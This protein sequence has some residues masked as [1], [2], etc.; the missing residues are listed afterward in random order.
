MEASISYFFLY[1][2]IFGCQNKFL[3]FCGCFVQFYFNR[4]V[5]RIQCTRVLIF[6][7]WYRWFWCF[8]SIIWSRM[9]ENPEDCGRLRPVK[10]FGIR[11]LLCCCFHK[12]SFFARFLKNVN[13]WQ[14]PTSHWIQWCG[15]WDFSPAILAIFFTRLRANFWLDKWLFRLKMKWNFLVSSFRKKFYLGLF[16]CRIMGQ[17]FLN[18][19]PGEV[20]HWRKCFHFCRRSRCLQILWLILHCVAVHWPC[21]CFGIPRT[22]VPLPSSSNINFHR[23]LFFE[24]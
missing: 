16:A 19:S 13:F 1:F 18:L 22:H 12:N 2:P 5:C 17:Q 11:P 15:F 8:V 10:I 3:F 6:P 4:L 24:K 23:R 21:G 9:M 20:F 7:V 14:L